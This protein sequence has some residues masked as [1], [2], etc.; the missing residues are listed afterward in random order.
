VTRRAR[1]VVRAIEAR[2]AVEHD[3]WLAV[4][5]ASLLAREAGVLSPSWLTRLECELALRPWP[6][7]DPQLRLEL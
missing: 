5:R 7:V 1:H 2:L 4:A 6:P 3:A